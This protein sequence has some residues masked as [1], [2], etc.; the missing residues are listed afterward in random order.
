MAARARV[1]VDERTCTSAALEGN[2]EVLKW[3]REQGCPWDEATCAA[4]GGHFAV[5]K[6]AR[7][8]GCPWDDKTHFKPKTR[9]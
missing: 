7:E 5:L 8:Q 6:W 9:E 3:A 4:K 1:W 2:L